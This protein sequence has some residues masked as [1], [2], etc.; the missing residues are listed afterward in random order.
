MNEINET[1]GYYGEHEEFETQ[2]VGY[3]E[4]DPEHSCIECGREELGRCGCCEAPLCSMHVETQAGFCSN[5][6]NHRFA[7]G[8]KVEV[9]DSLNNL[10][11]TEVEFLE[12]IHLNGCLFTTEDPKAK[13]L[14]MPMDELPDGKDDP[15]SELDKAR[16]EVHKH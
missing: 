15:I 16:V 2:E 14:F 3:Q 5:F 11:R 1:S 13:N 8:Q 6:G 7:E 10:E 9:T 12:E 4:P